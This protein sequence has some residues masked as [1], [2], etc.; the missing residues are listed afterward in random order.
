LKIGEISRPIETKFGWHI[1]K[2]YDRRKTSAEDLEAGKISYVNITRKYLEKLAMKKLFEDMKKEF[3]YEVIRSAIDLLVQKSDSARA[4]GIWPEGYPSSAYLNSS[5]FSKEE[6]NKYLVEYEGGGITVM[7]YFNE[8]RKYPAERMPE[9]RSEKVI[10]ELLGQMA[11][12]P[13]F[14]KLAYEEKFEK[15]EQFL[16]ELKFLEVSA[17][18]QKMRDSL[19]AAI[20]PVTDD[21]IEEYYR[22]RPEESYFPD[23]IR[24]SAIAVKTRE[25]ADGILQR[26]KGGA[27]FFQMAKKYSVDKKTGVIGGD[28]G[29]FTVK[30]FTPIYQAAEGMQKGDVGGPVEF[31]GNWW[32]FKLT[33]RMARRLKELHLVKADIESQLESNRQ[34]EAYDEYISRMKERTSFTIDLELVKSSLKTGKLVETAESKG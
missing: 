5:Y 12:S 3:H 30:R 8:M 10:E 16:T 26:I 23:Q 2:L 9:L 14:K 21:D 31:D 33:D 29:F 1:I 27:N 6:M 7:D 19:N 25:E 17:L 18:M 34:K 22:A 13:M 11:M 4:L 20:P 32:I 15:S 24:A 28:L